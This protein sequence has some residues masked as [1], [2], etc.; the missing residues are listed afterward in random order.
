MKAKLSAGLSALQG[1]LGSFCGKV[2][3]GQ[4]QIGR[5]SIPYGISGGDPSAAQVAVREAYAEKVQAWRTASDATREA[6]E[7]LA[8]PLKISGFNYWMTVT[9]M[10][11]TDIDP[12]AVEAA[13]LDSPIVSLLGNLNRIRYWITQITGEALGTV[14]HSLAATWAAVAAVAGT[15]NDTEVIYNDGGV[16]AGDP[17]LTFDKSTG[18]LSSTLFAGDGSGLEN[19]GQTV[20]TSLTFSVKEP[21]VIALK[22]GQAVYVSGGTAGPLPEVSLGDNT[23]LAKTRAVGLCATDINKNAAGK[24]RRGG[25]LT[26]VDTRS[27]NADVNPNAENWSPGD[28]LF[29]TS[30]GGLTNVRPTS[31]RSVKVAYTL[32][33]STQN[34]SLLI[35]PLEN[36]VWVTCAAGED[37]VLRVGDIAGVNKVSIRNFDNDEVASIDSLGNIVGEIPCNFVATPDTSIRQAIESVFVGIVSSFGLLWTDLGQQGAETYVYSLTYLGNGVAVAGTGLTGKIFR[38]IDNGLTWADLGQQGAETQVFSLAYLG[39]GVAVAGTFPNGKIFR[40]T[41]YGLTWADLGQQGAETQVYS[42]AYL[43]NGVA[44]AGTYPNGKIFRTVM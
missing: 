8:E 12:D 41:D 40:S 1:K 43:G 20:A 37:V 25:V 19:I 44:V 31:G 16:I 2:I 15:G 23:I 5:L 11:Q 6:W 24:I 13:T 32:S 33:G 22:K 35:Y 4:Q 36:P 18:L 26:L 29:M 9:D 38:S 21:N 30:G 34:D 14:S 39:N 28:L 17:A 10:L 3:R 7:I 27:T 42:L